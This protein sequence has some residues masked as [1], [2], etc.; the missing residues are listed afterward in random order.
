MID[1]E[2]IAMKSQK[3]STVWI[4]QGVEVSLIESLTNGAALYSFKNHLVVLLSANTYTYTFCI[5]A[6]LSSLITS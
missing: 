5:R 2:V 3:L 4:L 6:H 1:S